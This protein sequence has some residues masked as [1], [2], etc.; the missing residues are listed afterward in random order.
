MA[1]RVLA[2]RTGWS[3]AL[4]SPTPGTAAGGA[5]RGFHRAARRRIRTNQ[6]LSVSATASSS[7]PP[8][9]HRGA[10]TSTPLTGGSASEDERRRRAR[11]SSS[12]LG[13]AL[14]RS[15][16]STARAEN[17]TILVSALGI[18][19]VAYGGKIVA[20]QIDKWQTAKA[21]T[22]AGGEEG[23]EGAAASG[24]SSGGGLFGSLFAK[25]FYEGGFEDK[26]TR[27]EAALILG[28]RESSPKQKVKEAHRRVLLLNHPDRGG[29]T[30]IATKIN[31]AKE[32]LLPGAED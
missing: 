14:S 13:P 25:N 12:A 18:A 21:A 17:G 8:Y 20:E 26:M 7:S 4:A 2:H 6:R 24:S 1:L 19:G 16:H 22:A 31:E 9:S 29:S 15:L 11:G 10:A 30:H 3:R 5:A 23:E 32:M 27:R 28:I